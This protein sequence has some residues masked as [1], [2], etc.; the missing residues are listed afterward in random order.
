MTV[1]RAHCALVANFDSDF[2]HDDCHTDDC[3]DLNDAVVIPK[4][5][6]LMLAI[7]VVEHASH[8]GR[9]ASFTLFPTGHSDEMASYIKVQTRVV[10][11][12]KC[13]ARML[14]VSEISKNGHK[15]AE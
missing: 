8:S 7:K 1:Q 3:T 5:S 12:Q 14:Y 4:R 6:I 9:M 15:N 2:N 11:H 10:S 13:G